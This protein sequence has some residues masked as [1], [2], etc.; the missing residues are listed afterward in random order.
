MINRRVVFVGV[1]DRIA[2]GL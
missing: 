1:T 2:L